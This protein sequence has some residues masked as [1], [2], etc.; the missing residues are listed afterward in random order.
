MEVVP[1]ESKVKVLV[2]II[3]LI[4]IGNYKVISFSIFLIFYL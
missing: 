2:Q 3:I 1:P 4:I